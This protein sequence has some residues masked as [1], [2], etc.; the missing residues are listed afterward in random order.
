VGVAAMTTKTVRAGEWPTD[1]PAPAPFTGHTGPVEA[2]AVAELGGRPV[3]VSGGDKTGRGWALATRAQVG[4]PF[5]GHTGP[6]RGVAVAKV[7]ERPA[8]GSGGGA[9]TVRVWDLA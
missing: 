6:I 8:V 7:G 4:R 1:R 9:E 3:V 5:P 2:V